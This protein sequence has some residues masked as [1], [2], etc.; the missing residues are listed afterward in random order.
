MQSSHL[1]LLMQL[2]L[3]TTIGQAM[4]PMASLWKSFTDKL[5]I[6]YLTRVSIHTVCLSPCN[7]CP[8][9]CMSQFKGYDADKI[10]ACTLLLEGTAM[11]NNCVTKL[12]LHSTVNVITVGGVYTGKTFI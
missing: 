9:V 3:C 7:I 8:S 12:S 6:L 4:S 11:M 10:S 1:I 5:K 2:Q